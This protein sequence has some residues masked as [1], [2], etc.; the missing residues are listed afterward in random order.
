MTEATS[1]GCAGGCGKK[2]DAD[3]VERLGWSFLHITG[4]YRC[5]A[6]EFVLRRASTIEGAPTRLD[7]DT[8]PP[9]SLGALKKLPERQPLHEKVKP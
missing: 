9:N 2:V 6:C 8:L 7:V 1:I 4:R 5:G 3:Q